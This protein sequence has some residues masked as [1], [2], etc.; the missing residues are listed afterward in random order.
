MCWYV[1]AARCNCVKWFKLGS[2]RKHHLCKSCSTAL[3]PETVETHGVAC[4]W[5]LY[6]YLTVIRPVLEYGCAVWHRGHHSHKNWS[7][8]RR[9]PWESFTKLYVI[10]YAVWV[11]VCICWCTALLCSEIW[12]GE[13]VLSLHHT[14][15]QLITRTSS[16]TAWFRNSFPASATHC[17]PNTTN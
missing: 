12:I 10:D 7:L 8:C 9:G 13:E 3:L 4:G 5:L 6:F 2:T 17:L 16:P 1:Q 15:W 11:R 14:I